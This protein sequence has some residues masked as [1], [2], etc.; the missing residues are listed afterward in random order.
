MLIP[1][2]NTKTARWLACNLVALIFAA[3]ASAQPADA[4]LP[5]GH[6][7]A[8]P[9]NDY[10]VL[11]NVTGNVR[12]LDSKGLVLEKQ[13]VFLPRIPLEDLSTAQL[14]AL[15]ETRTA[16]AALTSF[17]SL[18]GTN[19]EGAVVEHQFHQIWSQGKSLAEQIQT[20]LEILE[21]MRDYNN[22][23]ALL[24][25]SVAAAS[26]YAINDTPINNR[27]TN[28]AAAVVV[29][30]AQV[31]TAEQDRDQ[32]GGTADRV[33]EQQAR[34]NYG[35]K[36]ARMEN[37]N[38]RAMIANGQVAGAN[39]QVVDHLAKCAALSSRLASHGI[40]VAGT[41]PF[42]PIPPLTM[43]AEVDAVRTAN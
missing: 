28:R 11:S 33:A 1:K 23:I 7:L 13:L 15:L 35:E 30:G 32:S 37:V 21:D 20:R 19:A 34:E 27:L 43:T 41:P 9:A 40:N 17:G 38:D 16:Y 3:R 22:E 24:P 36:V 29:A 42:Y 25:G 6:S 2:K 26:Q 8:S 12:V 4:N 14:Q 31:A 5:A 39:Q 10:L 18:H